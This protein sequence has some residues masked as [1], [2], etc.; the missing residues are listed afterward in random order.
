V[1]S[2]ETLLQI[3]RDAAAQRMAARRSLLSA[4]LTGS[5]AAGEPLLGEAT[6]IDL[7]LIDAEAPLQEREIVRLSDQVILDILYRPKHAYANAKTLRTDPWRGPEMCAPYFLSDPTHF[8][9]LA[10]ASVRGQFHR[11][12]YVVGRARACL[13]LAREELH[14]GA[15]PGAEP[16]APVTL[17]NFCQALWYASN[18]CLCL[19]G[20]PAGRR[21]LTLHLAQAQ[22][23]MYAAFSA[24]WSDVPLTAESAQLWLEDWSAAYLAGQSSDN[25]LIHPARRSVYA[26]GFQAQIQAGRGSD[27][28]WL[29]LYTWQACLKNLAGDS[30]HA[31][32]WTAFLEQLHM[33]SAANFAFRLRQVQQ[34]VEQAAAVVERWALANGE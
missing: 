3:A 2:R 16:Q 10:Q 29:M 9:E 33:G 24:L 32:R 14:L 19:N 31:D 27:C 17:A 13:H 30:L 26:R 34:Y 18:A 15:V 7:I 23:E 1:I 25:E 12:D 8:F 11:P 22:P 20:F 5:V 4:Y 6:D 21:R 28:W